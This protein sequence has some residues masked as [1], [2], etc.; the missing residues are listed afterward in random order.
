MG[1]A[2]VSLMAEMLVGTLVL[3]WAGLLLMRKSFRQGESLTKASKII[4]FLVALPSAAI[5]ALILAPE[6]SVN[7]ASGNVYWTGILIGVAIGLLMIFF[8]GKRKQNNE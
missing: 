7:S 5:A 8:A 6:A 1:F 2:L 4:G 3:Y